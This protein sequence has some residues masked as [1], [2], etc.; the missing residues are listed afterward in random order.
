[1]GIIYRSKNG[2]FLSRAIHKEETKKTVLALDVFF[3]L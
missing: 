3:S 1:L 2:F